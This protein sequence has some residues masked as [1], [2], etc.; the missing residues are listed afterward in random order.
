LRLTD[1]D[2]NEVRMIRSGE[3]GFIGESTSKLELTP[4]SIVKAQVKGSIYGTGEMMSVFGTCLNASDMPVDTGTY[5]TFNSWYPNGT[6]FFTDVVMSEMQLGYYVYQGAMQAVQGTYL[7]EMICHVNGSAEIAKAWGEW[8]NPRWVQQINDFNVTLA[9]SLANISSNFSFSVDLSLVYGNLTVLSQQLNQTFIDLSSQIVN[10]SYFDVQFNQTFSY[11]QNVTLQLTTMQN[12]TISGLE[13]ITLQYQSILSY[14]QNLTISM[15]DLTTQVGNIVVEIGNLSMNISDQFQQTWTN[16][17]ATNAYIN[18]TYQNITQ[19]L[20]VVSTVA[21][22]SVDRNNSYIVSLLNLI[23][24]GTSVPVTHVLN[25]T[26]TADSP[27]LHSN[28]EVTVQVENEY[29]VDVGYPL[30]SCFVNTTNVPSTV[31]RL[32]TPVGSSGNPHGVNTNPAFSW[33]EKINLIN[34]FNWAVWCVYN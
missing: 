3:S 22:S 12:L 21:N 1:G 27:I 19:Q 15:Q 25:V 33:T 8:Q 23:M 24:A 20:S 5:A 16:Q 9:A 6:I 10:Q 18:A 31:N 29:G 26:T 30:I 17:N 32:M 14:L 13:N 28:W 34:N 11:F 4:K 7:T 2:G